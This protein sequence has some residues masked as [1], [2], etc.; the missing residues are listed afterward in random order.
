[1]PSLGKIRLK[2]AP[3]LEWESHFWDDLV[4]LKD[5]VV[6]HAFFRE[7]EA[8]R[9]SLGQCRKGLTHFYRLVENFPKYMAL[10]LAKTTPRIR[11]GHA[12]AKDWLIANIYV[13]RRHAE[14]WRNWALGFGCTDDDLDRAEPGP[15][16]DAIN[17]YLWTVNTY[18]TL[19]EGLAATNLAIEWPTGEWTKRVLPASRL[20]E[21]RG[22]AEMND[23][24]LAWVEAHASYDDAHP[25]EAME[26]I[27]LCATTAEE[28]QRA[29]AAAARGL[30]YY[31]LAL[32]ECHKSP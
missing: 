1:M 17:N 15:V 4:P 18:G 5:R 13:E 3:R 32:D 31:L 10:N 28:R 19:A 29:F 9:L 11:P 23:R 25:Y 6:D 7:M 20:Y 22:L 26:L 12:E 27:G 14:L 8:G 2:I 16:M 30:E 24:T 21:K